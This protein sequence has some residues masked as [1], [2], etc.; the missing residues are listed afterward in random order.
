MC[1]CESVCEGGGGREGVLPCEF[2]MKQ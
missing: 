1:V 2:E